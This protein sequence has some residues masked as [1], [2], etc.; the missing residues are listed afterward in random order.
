MFRNYLG[1]ALRRLLGNKLFSFINLFGLAVGLASAILIGL[2]VADELSYDRFQP[3]AERLY[4]VARDFFPEEGGETHLATLPPPAAELLRQDYAEIE[5]VARMRLYP[6]LLR[7]DDLI[8]QE[9]ALQYADPAVFELFRFA[10]LA[11]DPRAALAAPNSIVLTERLARKYF[12]DEPALGQQL[13]LENL[14]D[15]TVTGVIRNLP[16][17]TH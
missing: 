13:Q 14:I 17:S 10:W 2:Y 16:S 1:L 9:D 5:A 6:G 11:G 12:G 8:Y 4:R 7:R 15:L 3:N